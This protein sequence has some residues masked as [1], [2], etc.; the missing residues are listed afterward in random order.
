M[1]NQV[2]SIS[3]WDF[4]LHVGLSFINHIPN[5]FPMSSSW[6]FFH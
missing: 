3:V 4:T 2:I 5:A 6:G 1:R